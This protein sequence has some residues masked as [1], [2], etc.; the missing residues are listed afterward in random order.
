M[1]AAQISRAVEIFAYFGRIS[2]PSEKRPNLPIQDLHVWN[3]LFRLRQMFSERESTAVQGV[4][5]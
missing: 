2:L 1:S 3:L 4:L 5:F